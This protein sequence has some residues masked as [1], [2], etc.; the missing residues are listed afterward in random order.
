MSL[1]SVPWTLV[2]S[3]GLWDK[4]ELDSIL[5]KGDQFFKFIGKFRYLGMEDLPQEFLVENFSINVEVLKNKT[6]NYSWNILGIYFRNCEW[7]SENWGT[8]S[9]HCQQL[10]FRSNFEK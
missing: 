7:Y 1:V 3:P 2:K 6:G 5:G 9:S 4:F 10:Y 8:S